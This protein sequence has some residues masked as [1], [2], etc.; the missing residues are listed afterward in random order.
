M[1]VD[2]LGT[3]IDKLTKTELHLMVNEALTKRKNFKI[4]TPNTE[5]VLKSRRNNELLNLL[6]SSSINIADG[7]GLVIASRLLGTPLGERLAGIELGEYLLDVAENNGLSVFLL[8]GEKGVADKAKKEIETRHKKIKICGT[9]HGYFDVNGGENQ[10]IL[11]E[12][13]SASPDILFVCMGFPR[14]ERWIAEN[15]DKIPS[16][17][18]S[19][20]LGGSL[21]VWSKAIRRAPK[22]FRLLCLEW[23]WRILRQPKRVSFIF[24]TPLFFVEILKQKYSKSNKIARIDSN[25]VH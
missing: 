19:I 1:K 11:N 25:N 21:D 12:I 4:F 6:N 8:G 18:L 14:Q 10:K 3:M 16:L 5:I 15:S 20:G 2:I 9:H 23:L 7:A 17:R 13:S 24:Q 22:L